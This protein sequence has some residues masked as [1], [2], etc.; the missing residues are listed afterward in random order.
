MVRQTHHE[1][2]MG[3]RS[4]HICGTSSQ[5]SLPLMK[6]VQPVAP[7]TPPPAG[8]N[9]RSTAPKTSSYAVLE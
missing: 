9:D 1:W 3:N 5:K 2:P 8:L 4:R 7:K 6:A